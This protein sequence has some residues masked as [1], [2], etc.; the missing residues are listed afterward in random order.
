MK[1]FVMLLG[2]LGGLM[3]L[4]CKSST[5]TDKGQVE[6]VPYAVVKGY[7]LKNDADLSLLKNGKITTEKDFFDL[8]GSATVM[9]KD[10]KPTTIDF[11]RQYVIAVVG[12]KTDLSVSM[13]PLT[14]Q[15]DGD[16]LTF[17]YDYKEGEKQ[18]YTTQPLLIVAVDSKYDGSVVLK[19]SN[20]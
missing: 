14:L 16:S 19:K 17:T 12:D 13:T 9:G 3:L 10:G 7:F 11:S 1:N 18:S 2:V 4:S 15:K 5:N 20:K 8:F 6:S